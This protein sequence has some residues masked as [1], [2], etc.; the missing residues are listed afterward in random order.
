VF[1][2]FLLGMNQDLRV[3]A[4]LE[5]PR[6]RPGDGICDH[7]LLMGFCDRSLAHC[8]YR[9]DNARRHPEQSTS[10]V[11]VAAELGYK[12]IRPWQVAPSGTSSGNEVFTVDFAVRTMHLPRFRRRDGLSILH[13][14]DLHLCGTPDRRF[15]QARHGPL[16]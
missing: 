7:L 14:S 3:E 16:P 9:R 13:L 10:T 11:D 6:G 4:E 5:R 2:W 8:G 1:L 15:Y 12:P